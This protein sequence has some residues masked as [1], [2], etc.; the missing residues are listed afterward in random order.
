MV[1]P[2]EHIVC[3]NE[4]WWVKEGNHHHFLLW[5][6]FAYFH[7]VGYSSYPPT[8]WTTPLSL[9]LRRTPTLCLWSPVSRYALEFLLMTAQNKFAHLFLPSY[10]CSLRRKRTH[11]APVWQPQVLLHD[12]VDGPQL[13]SSVTFNSLTVI[14]L[15]SFSMASMALMNLGILVHFLASSQWD[16]PAPSTWPWSSSLEWLV[17][18][19]KVYGPL[20]LLGQL[21]HVGE[22]GHKVVR[23]GHGVFCRSSAQRF[24]LKAVMVGAVIFEMVNGPFLSRL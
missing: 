17:P 5:L 10:C 1:R 7:R 21:I 22:G 12:L 19:W 4:A 20:D 13:L 11:L 23:S 16:P 8:G 15:S 3:I 9:G 24:I 18:F 6:A 14:L 2:F